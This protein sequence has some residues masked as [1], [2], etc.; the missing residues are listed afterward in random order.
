MPV[1]L[2]ILILSEIG[3]IGVGGGSGLLIGLGI[4]GDTAVKVI[5]VGGDLNQP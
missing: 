5:A 2:I 1:F 3:V 4:G